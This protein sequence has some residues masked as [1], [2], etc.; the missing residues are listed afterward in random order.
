MSLNI[1]IAYPQIGVDTYF[2]SFN[3]RTKG[4]DLSIK[5]HSADMNMSTPTIHAEI[6]QRESFNDIGLNDNKELDKRFAGKS[7]A[8]IQQH[9]KKKSNEGDM[10]ARIDKYGTKLIPHFAKEDMKDYEKELNV[11][12][13]PK[14]PPNIKFV[15]GGLKSNFQIG[16][17][18]LY[19]Q[20]NSPL[21]DV[22][23][24]H[25]DVYLLKKGD[26]DIQVI[27]RGSKVD[28]KV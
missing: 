18:S 14:N 11:D 20:Q 9:I 26:I 7:L 23:S 2:G 27:E 28:I 22:E 6:D 1:K 16:G 25:V 19:A 13:V 5:Q 15:G 4:A 21:I 8:K 12:C 3:M 24:A 17:M 10:M